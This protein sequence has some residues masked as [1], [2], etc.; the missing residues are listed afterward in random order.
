M[1]E[2][3]SVNPNTVAMFADQALRKKINGKDSQ[4]LTA[5]GIKH[6]DIIHLGNTDAVMT[7]VV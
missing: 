3:L 7:S 6:G 2:R 4:L 1:Q 5:L